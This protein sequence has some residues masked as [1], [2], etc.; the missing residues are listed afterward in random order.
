MP[1]RQNPGDILATIQLLLSTLGAVL[2]GA[3]SRVLEQIQSGEREKFWSRRLITDIVG[4][5]VMVL[6]SVGISE[7]YDFGR[8]AHGALAVG[9]GRLG[10]PTFDLLVEALLARVR[11]AK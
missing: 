6:I 2:V 1:W 4:V 9:L 7:Y 5:V 11:G 3:V 8:W 10:A